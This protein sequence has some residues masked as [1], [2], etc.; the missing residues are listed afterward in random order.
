MNR[1]SKSYLTPPRWRGLGN[2][3][4]PV[5]YHITTPLRKVDENVDPA[6]FRR[7]CSAFPH[8]GFGVPCWCGV[9]GPRPGGRPC[10]SPGSCTGQVSRSRRRQDRYGPQNPAHGGTKI[11]RT[12]LVACQPKGSRVTWQLAV[13]FKMC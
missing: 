7:L 2:R 3:S 10:W 9:G 13:Q 12:V 1:P 11:S 5:S 4:T 6:K 8:L